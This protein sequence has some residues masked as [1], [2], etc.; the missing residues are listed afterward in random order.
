MMPD[1]PVIGPR[2]FADG[3]CCDVYLDGDERQ[4]V[5]GDDGE[6]SY[7]QWLLSRQEQA[8]APLI[9]SACSHEG[10]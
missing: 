4:Y 9:I 2:Q 10:M 3:S 5:L 8:D 1:D 7:G 6:P